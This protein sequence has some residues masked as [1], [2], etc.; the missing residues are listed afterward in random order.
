MYVVHPIFNSVVNNDFILLIVWPLFIIIIGTP[1]AAFNV[2]QHQHTGMLDIHW[3]SEGN[4]Y[5]IQVNGSIVRV[6]NAS[7]TLP[8]TNTTYRISISLCPEMS[9]ASNFTI[10]MC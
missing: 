3:N 1:P 6:T 2:S 10:G 9:M 8:L 4:S 7:Y 5:Y